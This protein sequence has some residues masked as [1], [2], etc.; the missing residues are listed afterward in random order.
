MVFSQSC[1]VVEMHSGVL[2]DAHQ[3]VTPICVG[4]SRGMAQS[5]GWDQRKGK[6]RT[7]RPPSCFALCSII[8]GSL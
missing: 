8:G 4:P 3:P 5:S 7:A 2:R 1:Y 6:T